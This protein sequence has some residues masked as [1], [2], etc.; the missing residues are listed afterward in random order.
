MTNLTLNTPLHI[1]LTYPI[2]IATAIIGIVLLYAC[3]IGLMVM[4]SYSV[5]LWR[6]GFKC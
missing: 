5:V 3:V 1:L 4:Y 2:N 6:R